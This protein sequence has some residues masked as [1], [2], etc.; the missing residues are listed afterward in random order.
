VEEDGRTGLTSSRPVIVGPKFYFIIWGTMTLV[1]FI[2][3]APSC[4]F[5]GG[6]GQKKFPRARRILIKN[7]FFFQILFTE[8]GASHPITVHVKPPKN[9]NQSGNTRAASNS[10]N[11]GVVVVQTYYAR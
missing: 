11:L 7:F 10:I 1:I 6:G 4:Y 9:T 8:D 2:T 5:A 3:N